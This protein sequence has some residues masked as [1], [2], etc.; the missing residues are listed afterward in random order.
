MPSS[1]SFS[2]DEKTKVKAVLTGTKILS[3]SMARI[4]YAYPDPAKWAYAGLQ[5]A[6]AIVADKSKGAFYFKMV[7]M[8]VC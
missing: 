2:T 3:A 5:G 1:S 6:L 8:E 7:D 4:Y